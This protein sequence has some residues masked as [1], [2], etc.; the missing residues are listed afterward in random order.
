MLMKFYDKF[1]DFSKSRSQEKYFSEYN[2]KIVKKRK[3][4]LKIKT[5]ILLNN[6]RRGIRNCVRM[7]MLKPGGCIQSDIQKKVHSLTNIFSK[8][9]KT[10]NPC[11][12]G[13]PHPTTVLFTDKSQEART[14]GRRS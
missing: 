4:Y 7:Y 13:F 1:K 3:N 5:K 9:R 12:Q 8:I 10:K 2:K 14:V 11:K 6:P